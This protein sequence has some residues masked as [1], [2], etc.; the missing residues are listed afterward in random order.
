MLR[1]LG[2]RVIIRPEPAATQSES[3]IIFPERYG[4]PPAMSGTVVSVGRGSA[5]AHR[6]RQATITRC[7]EILN[8]IAAHVPTAALRMEVEAAL[9]QYAVDDVR[10]AEVQVGDYVA[11][12]FTAGSEMYVDGEPFVVMAEDDVQAVWTADPEEETAA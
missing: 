12:A 7:V 10:L 8:E 5:T 2:N 11:F 6:V 9:A 1:P 3:G 4:K